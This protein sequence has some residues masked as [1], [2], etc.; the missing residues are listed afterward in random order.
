MI[1]ASAT[2]AFVASTTL[3]ITGLAEGGSALRGDRDGLEVGATTAASGGGLGDRGG[4][5]GGL[6]RI[7]RQGGP[8]SGRL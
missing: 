7:V 6:E 3:T 2:G 4:V 1:G 5:G 8:S